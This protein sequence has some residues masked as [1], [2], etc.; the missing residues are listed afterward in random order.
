MELAAVFAWLAG[1]FLTVVFWLIMAPLLLLGG[2]I[3]G[4]IARKAGYSGWWGLIVLVP[5]L[6]PFAI[7][8]LAFVEWPRERK[9]IEI[10][11]PRVS[12]GRHGR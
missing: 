9:A 7:W 11:P 1:L 12:P 2:W 8:A 5:P 3:I 10:I 4:R 6:W